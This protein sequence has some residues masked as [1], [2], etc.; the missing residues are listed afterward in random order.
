MECSLLAAGRP[1]TL[2]RRAVSQCQLACHFDRAE[3][4]LQCHGREI[5]EH[6]R[7]AGS[8]ARLFGNVG[9][10]RGRGLAAAGPT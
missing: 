8:P 6:A 5:P 3:Q 9:T 1:P 7:L 2:H 4:V 10:A